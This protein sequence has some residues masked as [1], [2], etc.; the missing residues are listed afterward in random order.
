MTCMAGLLLLAC[1]HQPAEKPF[2]LQSGDLLF[3]D[4]D[5][6]EM[7]TAIETVTHGW[8]GAKLSHVGIVVID[9]TGHIKVLE[10]ISRGV[11]LTPLDSFLNRSSDTTHNPKVIVGRLKIPNAVRFEKEAVKRAMTYLGKPYD[12]VYNIS[13]QAYYCS[14]LVYFAYQDSL[15]NSLF[16]LSPMTYNDPAT[17]TIFPVWKSYF[18]GMH[19]PVPEGQPGINP[20]G[21]SRSDKIEIIHVYGN[22]TGMEINSNN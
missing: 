5:C 16:T 14:E 4:L 15:G 17:N 2:A 9:S 11:S 20:G 13:N 7:C 1:S 19:V 8:H 6:G 21:I 22:P 10:A 12:T 18:D 3:Q